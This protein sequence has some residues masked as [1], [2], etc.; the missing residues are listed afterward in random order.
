GTAAGR[1]G[2]RRSHPLPD[3]RAWFL[4][5]PR[6]A[7]AGVMSPRQ[8]DRMLRTS[9]GWGRGAS[10][11]AGSTGDL[12]QPCHGT[13]R[14]RIGAGRGGHRGKTPRRRAR[15]LQEGEILTEARQGPGQGRVRRG[16]AAEAQ[17]VR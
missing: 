2:T 3:V 4:L 8:A 15:R 7:F 17:G 14:A 12:T 10:G 9:M 16:R 5:L 1:I 13:T 11:V 6:T